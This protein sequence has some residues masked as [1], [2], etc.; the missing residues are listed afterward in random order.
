MH[1]DSSV[2]PRLMNEWIFLHYP[3]GRRKTIKTIIIFEMKMKRLSFK[4]KRRDFIYSK[5][6]FNI[7]AITLPPGETLEGFLWPLSR[8]YINAK[9]NPT[10]SQYLANRCSVPRPWWDL[11][12]RTNDIIFRLIHTYKFQFQSSWFILSVMAICSS[13]VTL[14]SFRCHIISRLFVRS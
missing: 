8:S 13:F 5:L 4:K 6:H 14:Y 11:Q 3:W 10:C 1:L 2:L 12:D 9:R 7:V